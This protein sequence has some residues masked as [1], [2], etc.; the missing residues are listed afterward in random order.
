MW[1]RFTERSWCAFSLSDRHKARAVGDGLIRA[2][3]IGKRDAPEP[4][5]VQR[6]LAC[7]ELKVA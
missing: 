7:V 1:R 4:L 6:P 2:Q 3:Q 5:P